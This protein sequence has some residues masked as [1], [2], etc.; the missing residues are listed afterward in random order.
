MELGGDRTVIKQRIYI[1]IKGVWF[2]VSEV[3]L[4]KKKSKAFQKN[5]FGCLGA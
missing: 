2:V 5:S 4:K 3:G 1:K